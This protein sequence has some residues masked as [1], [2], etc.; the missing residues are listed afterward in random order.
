MKIYHYTSATSLIGIISHAKLWATDIRFLNDY[1][2]LK[3]GLDLIKGKNEKFWSQY[4]VKE[5][6]PFSFWSELFNK[7]TRSILNFNTGNNVNVISFTTE[8]DYIRQWM[9]YC[10]KNGGYCIEFDLAKLKTSVEVDRESTLLDKVYYHEQSKF[11]WVKGP[12]MQK[13]DGCYNRMLDVF[14]TELYRNA[15][16]DKRS[17]MP[18]KVKELVDGYDAELLKSYFNSA[19]KDYFRESV[20]RAATVKPEE[21]EDEKEYRIVRISYRDDDVSLSKH[22]ERNGI[23]VPYVEVPFDISSIT[24][25]IIGPCGDK[26]LAEQGIISLL[27]ALGLDSQVTISHS[28]C[29]LRSY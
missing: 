8:A 16:P 17:K 26:D 12:I 25:V 9:A 22:R 23:V 5:E 10:P 13:V 3:V 27:K 20:F 14:L 1:N 28:T 21:F 6:H 7:L 24:K 18:S 15:P 29:S 2:E 19:S 11:E 4:E